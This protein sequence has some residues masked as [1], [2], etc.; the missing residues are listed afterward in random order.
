MFFDDVVSITA[1]GA[2]RSQEENNKKLLVDMEN[3][4]QANRELK[5]KIEVRGLTHMN[6]LARF[7]EAE[8]D[9]T[10][11][12]VSRSGCAWRP[13]RGTAGSSSGRW[14]RRY[15]SASTS[16]VPRNAHVALQ[17]HSDGCDAPAS[18]L[19]ASGIP[20]SGAIEAVGAWQDQGHGGY[21]QEGLSANSNC[22]MRNGAR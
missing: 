4:R 21:A 18:T 5:D 13:R 10:R 11:R 3:M 9:C 8:N 17:R 14:Q 16:P 20:T 6:D 12:R 15:G 2:C 19:C 1:G 7:N 22:R